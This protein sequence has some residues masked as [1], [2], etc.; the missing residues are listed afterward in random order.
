Y[1]HA[2]LRRELERDGRALRT[3]GDT[4]VVLELYLRD[5]A[6][7]ARSLR[8][9]F[10]TAIW[11]ARARRLVLARDTMGIKP[12]FYRLDGEGLAF[13]S[14]LRSLRALP[15]FDGEISAEALHAYL[16]HNS[17]PGPLT[18]FREARKLRPGH[19]LVCED[20]RA[21]VERY[22]RPAPVRPSGLRGEPR[23]ALAAE[24]RERLRDSVRAHLVSDVP[25]GVLLS[26][27][28]D[29]SILTAIASEQS[30][31]PPSTFS[32]G[33]AERSFDELDAAR[34]VARRFGT[35]HHELVVE[36]QQTRLLAQIAA[37]CD[38]PL[39]DSSALP[40]F[41]VAGMASQH[42]KVVLS[43][44]G[45]DELFGGYETYAADLLAR[46]VPRA[47][48]A[49]VPLLERIPSSD[50]RVSVE[51]RAKRFLAAVGLPPLERHL[52]WKEIFAGSARNALLR[53]R[54]REPSGDPLS[55]H[56]ARYAETDGAPPLAR[57]QDVDLGVY[58]VD[59]LLVKTDRMTMAHSLEARVPFLDRAVWELALALP[60]AQKVRGM[61]KKRLLRLAGEEWLPRGMLAG[62]K[63][64]F[65][66]PAAAW[67]RGV[68]APFAREVLSPRELEAQGFFEPAVVAALLDEHLAR[69]RD[70]SRQLWGLLC[71]TL[72][73][74]SLSS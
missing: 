69:T 53:E 25:V 10:A 26:G 16:T 9:M 43:G 52:A 50:G 72:W 31:S 35:E 70:H 37:A 42:V 71:F 55:A 56:R 40:T 58:L 32:I 60:D 2:Q 64:G 15:S 17:I 47:L 20:G 63:R 30:P 12:L 13:A 5:G 21:S 14:E 65:S 51:Y 19:V 49:A 3:S 74:S 44:E 39:G 22:A 6:R 36:P 8:G 38:E 27:G 46:R 4:E 29:S 61:D 66:I 33:F 48:G 41:L 57:L 11:D 7:F 45:A 67:L 62:R 59:D 73:Y 28:V 23:A 24:L 18:I 68:L 1:N 54:W 34:A